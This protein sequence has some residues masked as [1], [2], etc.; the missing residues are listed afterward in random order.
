MSK[1]QL[2]LVA[3]DEA[4]LPDQHLAEWLDADES[5]RWSAF[6]KAGPRRRFLVAHAAL[7]SALGLIT[8]RRP[9]SIRFHKNAW[10]RPETT[11]G[12][13]FNMSHSGSRALIAVAENGCVGVDIEAAEKRVSSDVLAA[14]SSAAERR[15]ALGRRLEPEDRLRLWVRKEAVLKAFGR[16]LSFSPHALTVGAHAADAI[17]WRTTTIRESGHSRRFSF[18]DLGLPFRLLGA[19]AVSGG[20][21][22]PRIEL[23]P[24]TI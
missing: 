2:F 20:V 23:R 15:A 6:D 14:L 16:G 13:S 9:E 21:D 18:I 7:R 12:P 1:L 4:R 3:L 24:L 8:G 11:D 17:H 5:A 10:G 19:L 22:D